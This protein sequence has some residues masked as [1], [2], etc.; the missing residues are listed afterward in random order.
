MKKCIN[1]ELRNVTQTNSTAQIYMMFFVRLDKL[2]NDISLANV[3]FLNF[4]IFRP[5][6]ILI[7]Y[8]R[9]RISSYIYL[10]KTKSLIKILLE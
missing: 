2:R 4:L 1:S 5:L 6:N 10:E 8:K 9:P 3:S 7:F